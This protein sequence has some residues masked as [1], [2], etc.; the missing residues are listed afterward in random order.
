VVTAPNR[1]I[2]S[3]AAIGL[4]WGGVSCAGARNQ[5]AAHAHAP[6]TAGYGGEVEFGVQRVRAATA[7]FV[8]LDSAVAAGYAGVVAQCYEHP[9]HGAMGYHH[10][11][12]SLMDSV[13]EVERPEILVYE[14]LSDGRYVLNGVEYI[15][16]Y[17][18]WSPDSAAPT[19]MGLPLKHADDLRLWYLHAWVWRENTAGLFAD[20]NPAVRCPAG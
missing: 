5:T 16:P 20:W 18:R 14:R 7:A 3:V 17:S 10:V 19:I 1:V 4:L 11:N 8:T 9:Q 2:N 15:V 13:L 6:P 12:R